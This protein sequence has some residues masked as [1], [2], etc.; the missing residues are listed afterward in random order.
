MLKEVWIH[1]CL[2]AEGQAPALGRECGR[3]TPWLNFSLLQSHSSLSRPARVP[4]ALEPECSCSMGAKRPSCH[5][6]T[7]NLYKNIRFKDAFGCSRDEL[8]FQLC[9]AV[10]TQSASKKRLLLRVRRKL[11][12]GQFWKP[13]PCS[14]SKFHKG[15]FYNKCLALSGPFLELIHYGQEHLR[16]CKHFCLMLLVVA[17]A[18]R[19]RVVGKYRGFRLPNSLSLTRIRIRSRLTKAPTCKPERSNLANDFRVQIARGFLWKPGQLS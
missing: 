3:P 11:W 13:G 15:N 7:T 14:L 2:Y 19:K 10:K 5:I 17:Q 6:E 4:W 8:E 16:A 12:D 9:S 18:Q 1:R